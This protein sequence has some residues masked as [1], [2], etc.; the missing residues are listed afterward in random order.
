MS[1][2][3]IKIGTR[4]SK[5]ALWQAEQVQAAISGAFPHLTVEIEIIKTKGDIILDVA[6]SKIGDKGLFTKEIE[7]ALINGEI[8]L[9]V[10]SLKDLPTEL[11]EGL[12][13]GG[14]LPRGEVRDVL[15]SKDGR[16]LTEMTENDRIATSSL[17]RKA[18]LLHFNPNLTIVDIRG[19]VD[20]RIQKMKDGHCDALV[21]AGAGIIRLGY[22][23]L[24]TE[25][26][27]P[28]VILPAVSQGAVAIEI[29]EDDE[30]IQR[31]V[32]AVSDELTWQ[33]TMA[34]RWLLRTLEGGC[35]VPVACYSEPHGSQLKLTGLVAGLD[36]KTVI[37]KTVDCSLD[38]ASEKAI[39]LAQ[40][41]L[42]EGGR[43]ILDS[44]R[45]V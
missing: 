17:R 12:I 41:I 24:I 28:T 2:K 43:E 13:I 10:H 5:L 32:D 40:A 42:D 38:E 30:F 44:I 39:E 22:E 18:Q 8:D 29:R 34:E 7:T 33:T 6:L 35:Q 25:F 23:K 45:T 19:N 16:K 4:G 31:V 26:L 3:N 21:M 11:P 14:M 20:T 37:R 9:A 27:D 36:G 1:K 15:I